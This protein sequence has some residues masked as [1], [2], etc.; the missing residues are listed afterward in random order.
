M[1]NKGAIELSEFIKLPTNLASLNVGKNT[2]GRVGCKAVAT[3]IRTNIALQTLHIGYS[4][5]GDDRVR[6]ILEAAYEHPTL[7]EINVEG[8]DV[9]DEGALAILQ[10]VKENN[11]LRTVYFELDNDVSPE[12]VREIANIL[13]TRNDIPETR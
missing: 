1:K 7:V 6:E 8:N 3:G 2:F 10:L 12:M 11:V 5:F 13:K 4:H 9:T